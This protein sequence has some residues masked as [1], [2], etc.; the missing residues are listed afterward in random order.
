LAVSYLHSL[1]GAIYRTTDD[2]ERG[3]LQQALMFAGNLMGLLKRDPRD[4]LEPTNPA[5]A[6]RIAAR[7]EARQ[8]RDFAEADL[9]RDELAAEGWTLEDTPDGKTIPRR[10]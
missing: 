3:A 10:A 1:T 4:W 9:I 2:D 5:V 7:A 6:G 8:R